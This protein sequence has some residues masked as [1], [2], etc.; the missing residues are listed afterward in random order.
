[1]SHSNQVRNLIADYCLEADAGHYGRWAGL[2]AD[3][4]CLL[5]AGEQVGRGPDEL[6]HWISTRPMPD[7]VHMVSN[8]RLRLEDDV[9]EAD[10]DF[11]T[12]LAN[13]SV[14]VLGRYGARFVRNGAGWRI[15]EWRIEPRI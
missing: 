9:A 12:I 13:R 5:L 10:M 8:I 6:Q 7:G 1:M 2:F 14:G 11:V 4:A 3:D 15:A